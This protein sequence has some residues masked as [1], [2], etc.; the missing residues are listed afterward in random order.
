[1]IRLL[2]LA[3]MV[4][5]VPLLSEV[6]A[7]VRQPA[8]FVVA[9]D[10]AGED[11]ARNA[12]VVRDGAELPA[13]IM[14]PLFAGDAVVVRDPASRIEIEGGD[15][16]PSVVGGSVLRIDI[17]GEIDTGDSAWGVLAA[18]G[19]VIGGSAEL[20]PENMVSKGESP[21]VPLAIRGTNLLPEGRRLLWLPWTGGSAPFSVVLEADGVEAV[22]HGGIAEQE[23]ILDLAAAPSERFSLTISDA[24]DQK[25]VIRFARR[26]AMPAPAETPPQGRLGQIAHAAWL[27]GQASGAWTIE[28]AQQLREIGT[29]AARSVLRHL[30]TT[31]RPSR[32]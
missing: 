8:A 31:P 27:A 20:P 5:I 29:P 2:V 19:S 6:E 1:M 17:S 11:L 18:I 24:M 15:G 12:S 7:D 13:K 16:S 3:L 30:E 14:M 32:Y 4:L 25:A 22:V 23:M 26:D 9:I 28:A 10:L 21:M